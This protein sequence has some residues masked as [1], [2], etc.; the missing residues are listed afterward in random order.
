MFT[1]FHFINSINLDNFDMY[2]YAS[3]NSIPNSNYDLISTLVGNLAIYDIYDNTFK[4]S[5]IELNLEVLPD[6]DFFDFDNISFVNTT[7]NT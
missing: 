2:N 7:S 1:I 3:Y 6:I 4:I 5:K